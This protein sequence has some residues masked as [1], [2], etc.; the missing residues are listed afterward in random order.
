MKNNF[1]LLF[2]ILFL[3]ACSPQQRI[4]R[5]AEK[6]NLKQFETVVY[7]DT[8]YIP[9]KVYILDTQIDT[10]GN[11][12][13]KTE[14]YEIKGKIKDSIIYVK[15]TTAPDT[16][17]IEKTVNIETIKVQTVEKNNGVAWWKIIVVCIAG[18]FVFVVYK[19]FTNKK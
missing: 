17:Y 8:I 7:K 13:K 3:S 12:Y 10:A 1:I 9:E 16:V 6:Y 4:A 5:I 14:N 11:F 19:Y 15:F 18:G 2:T